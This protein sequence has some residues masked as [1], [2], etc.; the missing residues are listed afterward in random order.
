M[1]RQ[2]QSSSLTGGGVVFALKPRDYG[3]LFKKTRCLFLKSALTSKVNNDE[4]IVLDELTMEDY[5]TKRAVEI[6][7]N[8]KSEEKALIVVADT[9]DYVKRSFANIP[10]VATL[11]IN[12]IN[13]YDIVR[14]DSLV[15]TKDALERIEEVYA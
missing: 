3:Y 13:V 10:F 7:K 9:S 14:Y 5:S 12:E 6:L 2:Y 8:I 4:L 1:T 11:P 15:L